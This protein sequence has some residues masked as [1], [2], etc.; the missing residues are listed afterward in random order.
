M[1][2]DITAKAKSLIPL[3]KSILNQPKVKLSSSCRDSQ[4]FAVFCPIIIHMIECEQLN[5]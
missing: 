4:F 1:F 3:R 5:K 2:A